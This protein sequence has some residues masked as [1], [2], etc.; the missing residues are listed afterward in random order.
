MNAQRLARVQLDEHDA[1]RPH[2]D[3]AVVG[4]LEDDLRASVEARLRVSAGGGIE[5]RALATQLGAQPPARRARRT[6]MYLYM[7]ADFGHDEP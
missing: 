7:V 1:E 2:V 3:G 4:Q 5:V 6:W